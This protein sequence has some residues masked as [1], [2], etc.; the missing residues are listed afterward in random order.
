ML[1]DACA[2][3]V[4]NVQMA[5]MHEIGR[6]KCDLER[7]AAAPFEYDPHHIAALRTAIAAFEAEETGV[8]ALQRLLRLLEAVR[9]YHD[10]LNHP[11]A[12]DDE[13]NQAITAVMTA[14]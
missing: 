9:A 2:D 4:R 1:S 3:L 8:Q 10:W 13:I 5:A 11:A 7:Y 6:F 12:V 14:S